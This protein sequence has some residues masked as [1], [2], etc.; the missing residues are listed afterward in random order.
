MNTPKVTAE[1]YGTEVFLRLLDNNGL[2]IGKADINKN[3]LGMLKVDVSQRGKGYGKLLFKHALQQVASNGFSKMKLTAEP[4]QTKFDAP[5]Y[6]N[7]LNNLVNMYK[8]FGAVEK[9]RTT[10]SAEM[11][12]PISRPVK[13]AVEDMLGPWGR[14]TGPKAPGMTRLIQGR[15][16]PY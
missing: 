8:S 1:I 13:A 15:N 5:E 7:V 6:P 2:Q 12:V 16:R 11:Y 14:S 4:F 3:K 10:E 9:T